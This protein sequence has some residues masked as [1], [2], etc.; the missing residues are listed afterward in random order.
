MSN[1]GITDGRA[2]MAGGAGSA[3]LTWVALIMVEMV[4]GWTLLVGGI[5][6]AAIIGVISYTKSN[7]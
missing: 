3:V 1:N 7:R 5:F 6:A 4:A 2:L